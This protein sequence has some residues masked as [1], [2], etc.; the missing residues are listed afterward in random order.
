MD[1]W[2]QSSQIAH[3]AQER[4]VWSRRRGDAVWITWSR[5]RVRN[6]FDH[7]SIEELVRLLREEHRGDAAAIVLAGE[8]GHFSSGDD[9]RET[10]TLSRA[11]WIEVN[12]SWAE[13]TEALLDAPQPVIACVEGVCLGGGFEIACACDIVVAARDAKLGCPEVTVG[14]APSN[15]FTATAPRAAWPAM[16]TGELLTAEEAWRIGLVWRVSD[17]PAAEVERVVTQLASNSPTAVAGVKRVLVGAER[18]RIREA[19]RT[20]ERL[21][22]QLFDHEG[23]ASL[24][25]FLDKRRP[26]FTARAAPWDERPS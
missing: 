22:V 14:L 19:M 21:S 17:E 6:A 5:P 13:V 3:R 15:G 11:E 9:L 26:A 18:S 25:A 1:S 24:R 16:L 12:R 2:I 8:D 23:A 20:E 4:S 7:A 10:A